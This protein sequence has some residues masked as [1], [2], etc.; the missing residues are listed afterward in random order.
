MPKREDIK[1]RQELV[2]SLDCIGMK[3]GGILKYLTKEGF[4]IKYWSV[5]RDLRIVR[6][7]RKKMLYTN[8]ADKTRAEYI[9]TQLE[10]LR[11]A[12]EN[13]DYRTA[14]DIAD[15]IAKARGVDIETI[16]KIKG[17]TLNPIKFIIEGTKIPEDKRGD[18]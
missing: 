10:L 4:S 1:E 18:I 5:I 8:E 6:K 3:P 2:D 14:T 11:R 15:K 7:G 13:K 12:I 17:D 9:G 16:I